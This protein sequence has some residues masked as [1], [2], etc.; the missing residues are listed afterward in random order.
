MLFRLRPRPLPIRRR[1]RRR[2]RPLPPPP[3]LPIRRRI[4]TPPLKRRMPDRERGVEGKSVGL[5]GGRIIKKKKTI[6][7]Q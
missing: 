6:N 7:T 4:R 2:Y 5:G 3:P 1:S